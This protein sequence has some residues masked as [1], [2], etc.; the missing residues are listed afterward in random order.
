MFVSNLDGDELYTFGVRGD[1]PGQFVEPS[2]VSVDVF[3]NVLIADSK[4]DR[5]Q[6]SYSFLITY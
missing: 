3:G 4:N 2:G 6:V 1:A 5:L